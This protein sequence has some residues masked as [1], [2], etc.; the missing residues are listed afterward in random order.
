MWRFCSSKNITDWKHI[1]AKWIHVTFK[2]YSFYLYV[3]PDRTRGLL[4]FTSV[5][6]YHCHRNRHNSVLS[7]KFIVLFVSKWQFLLSSKAL[8]PSTRFASRQ[9]AKITCPCSQKLCEIRLERES[10]SYIWSIC[11]RRSV[12][13]LVGGAWACP[14]GMRLRW[15]LMQDYGRRHGKGAQW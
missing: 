8:I 12:N 5:M 11:I 1:Y 15:T 4:F 9:I 7:T 14:L 10:A 6:L 2:L 13:S 3:F